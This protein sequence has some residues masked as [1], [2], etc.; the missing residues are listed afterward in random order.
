MKD[1]L[2][3]GSVVTRAYAY[4]VEEW[5]IIIEEM[6]YKHTDLVS[7]PGYPIPPPIDYFVVMWPGGNLTE[8]M[9]A[10]LLSMDDYNDLV[11]KSSNKIN[12]KYF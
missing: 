5:G 1:N 8:E 4:N 7:D 12:E 2:K 11:A 6:C 3:T 10:E 9:D